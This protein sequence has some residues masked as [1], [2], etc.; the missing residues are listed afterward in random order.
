MFANAMRFHSGGLVPGEVPAILQRGEMVIPRD[1]ARASGGGGGGGPINVT[2]N[3]APA[4]STA[5]VTKKSRPGGGVDIQLSLRRMMRD[6]MVSEMSDPNSPVHYAM[7]GDRTR[8][9][10]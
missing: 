10:G 8:G 5:D 6:T 2:V 7:G 4:G 9:M 3:N 1:M